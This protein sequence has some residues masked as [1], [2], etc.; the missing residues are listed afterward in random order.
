MLF[1]AMFAI[2]LGVPIGFY[3]VVW[4]RRL[5][6]V[7]ALVLQALGLVCFVSEIALFDLF[8]AFGLLM[9]TV[10]AVR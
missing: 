4:V 7:L 9:S 2:C 6:I 3:G 5:L 10:V 8:L 1:I